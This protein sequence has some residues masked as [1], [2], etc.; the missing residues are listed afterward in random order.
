[1][2]V[3][4]K[5][6]DTIGEDR[7]REIVEALGRAGFEARSLFPGQTR[8]KLASIFTVAGADAKDVQAVHAALTK[9]ARDIEYV[10][11]APK[12]RLKA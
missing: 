12:R 11:G 5:L 4:F 2:S 6:K 3:Q 7:R 1:M 10:E 8:P 9:Y